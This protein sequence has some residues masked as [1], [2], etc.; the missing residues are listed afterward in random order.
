MCASF[1]TLP[2]ATPRY[3]YSATETGESPTDRSQSTHVTRL[4]ASSRRS[5][6]E[7]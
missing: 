3:V 1:R 4:A 6:A 7:E 2:V 5:S